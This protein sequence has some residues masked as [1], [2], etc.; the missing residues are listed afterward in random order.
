MG[1]QVV[2]PKAL[3]SDLL[4]DLLKMHHQIAATIC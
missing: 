2:I 1:A 4:S 3:Q